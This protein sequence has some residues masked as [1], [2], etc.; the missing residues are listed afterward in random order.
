MIMFGVL[1]L[2]GAYGRDYKSKAA[3]VKDW[4][5]GKDFKT[6]D[7][8]QAYCVPAHYFADTVADLLS[9]GGASA[10][11]IKEAFK[12]VMNKKNYLETLDSLNK[13][14]FYEKENN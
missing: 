10:W 6:A 14:T 7:P 3:I 1:P 2:S 12:P 11:K 13:S 5:D 4:L 8:E 9:D